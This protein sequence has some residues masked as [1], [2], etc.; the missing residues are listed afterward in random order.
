[1]K[2]AIPEATRSLCTSCQ[3]QTGEPLD[4]RVV[5]VV[6]GQRGGDQRPRVGVSVEDRMTRWR[7]LVA[8]ARGPPQR[9]SC[10][11][12]SYRRGAWELRYREPSG[13]ERTERF[14]AT[15]TK[16]PPEEALDRRADIEQSLRRHRYVPREGREA[17]FKDYLDRWWAARRVSRGPHVYR[18]RP[19]AT[20]RAAAL[21]CLAAV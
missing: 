13:V 5:V 16:R 2:T 4:A 15:S 19:G 17:L 21:G 10:H 12:L 1:M 9:A 6:V 11:G 14:A 8:E 3:M 18:Y 20:A 7:A